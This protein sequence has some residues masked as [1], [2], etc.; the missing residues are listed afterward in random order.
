M[1]ATARSLLGKPAR[2]AFSERKTKIDDIPTLKN[3]MQ[4]QTSDEVTTELQETSDM[5]SHFKSYLENQV[6]NK[7]YFIET[8]GCQ[9]N[10]SDSEIVASIM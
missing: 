9:M 10:V 1:L 3:F 4:S 5:S 2:R 7:S 6:S 8:H